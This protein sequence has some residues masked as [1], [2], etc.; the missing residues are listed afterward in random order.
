MSFLESSRNIRIENVENATWLFCEAQAEDGTW[1]PADI[2]L[3]EVIGNDDGWFSRNTAGFTES[4]EEIF[5]QD[6]WLTANLP[7]RDGSYRDRQ[8][9]DL[10]LHIT[11]VNG[12]LEWYGQ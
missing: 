11:N 7:R 4:A 10:G 2:N 3:D 12:N 5:F 6:G 1:Q 8:G 9:I